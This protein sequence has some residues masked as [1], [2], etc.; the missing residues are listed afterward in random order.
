MNSSVPNNTNSY[1]YVV[2]ELSDNDNYNVSVT[3][4]GVSGIKTS[5]PITVYSKLYTCQVIH[6]YYICK[7]I[8]T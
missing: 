1:M 3:A 2:T 8:H 6:S 7:Y 5:D 4:V